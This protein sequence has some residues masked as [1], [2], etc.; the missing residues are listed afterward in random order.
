M[1]KEYI[2]N[3]KKT[4]V[5]FAAAA[6]CAAALPL[7]ACQKAPERTTYD[8]TCTY[9]EERGT[10]SAVCDVTYVNT[11]DTDVIKFNI[12]G[13]AYREGALYRPVS[14]ELTGSA[15]YNGASY[16]G[17]Q[18]TA[19]EGGEW[20]ICGE[21]EN[22][23]EVTLPGT[24]AG[25]DSCNISISYTLELA[26]V[27]HRTG[28]AK[29]AVNLG[30]FYPVACARDGDG[31]FLECP[32]YSDGDPFLS[33]CADYKV[34]LTVPEG[35]T[36]A[37]SGQL[38]ESSGN[39]YTYS[40]EN[41]RDFCMVISDEFERISAE[42]GGTQVYYYYY[43]DDNAQAKLD[44]ACQS[45]E[46]F[47]SAFGEYMW[48]TLSVVQTG[49]AAGGMEY[50]ALTMIN[51]GLDESGAIAAI[52]HEN[53]HQW[54]YAMVGSD[55][56]NCAWQDEG[57]AEYSALMFF[58]NSP[59]YGVTRTGLVNAAINAYR[60]YFTVYNQIFGDA[61]TSMTRHLKDF[62]SDYEYVNIAYNK[63]LILFDTLRQS[64]GD[65]RFLAGLKSYFAENKGKIAK[66]DDLIA[67]FEGTGVDVDGLFA[68]FIEGKVII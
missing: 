23:L 26:E 55:Q 42:A 15:Y 6:V 17:V 39:T 30:N 50:P 33:D 56:I 53:A 8:I 67:C 61:D 51:G 20:T 60:A 19:V 1:D 46:Y 65:D 63:G 44:A 3:I 64:I 66:S 37:A 40:L 54:W 24:L 13:N 9:S 68:S 4:A 28:I 32:Y 11:A 7:A 36:A 41:A 38:V 52:V 59:E 29:H 21:D 22:I 12:Y 45:L 31:N 16:G 62:V 57:L 18:I 48:P 43:S 5:I 27:N 49:F 34:T 47:K 14:D 10:L 2:K 25:G 35:Y 58:E